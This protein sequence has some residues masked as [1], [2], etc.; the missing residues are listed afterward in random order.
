MVVNSWSSSDTDTVFTD[1]FASPNGEFIAYIIDK[2][3]YLSIDNGK[4]YTQ[5][6]ANL[7]SL[8]NSNGSTLDPT[9][10]IVRSS[11][12]GGSQS[13][14]TVPSTGTEM[15][16]SFIYSVVSGNGTVYARGS[17]L[18]TYTKGDSLETI[19]GKT[20]GVDDIDLDTNQ[21]GNTTIWIGASPAANGLA[22][23]H[24][25][26]IGLY[27]SSP[28]YDESTATGTQLLENTY[29]LNFVKLVGIIV[30]GLMYVTNSGSTMYFYNDM[31]AHP[32]EITSTYNIGGFGWEQSQITDIG[33]ENIHGKV[34]ATFADGRLGSIVHSN[35]SGSWKEWPAG[36]P[37]YESGSNFST[38]TNR[39]D[40]CSVSVDG[41]TVVCWEKGSGGTKF[42]LDVG[43]SVFYDMSPC[44]TI[45]NVDKLVV[46]SV[47]GSDIAGYYDTLLL[48]SSN[49]GLSCFVGGTMIMTIN[50]YARVE[51]LVVGNSVLTLDGYRV[52]K[53]IH[54]CKLNREDNCNIFTMKNLSVIGGH[55]IIV[56]D[57]DKVKNCNWDALN[58]ETMHIKG[59]KK[60]MAKD[61]KGFVRNTLDKDFMYYHFCLESESDTEQFVVLSNDIPSESMSIK[62][63]DR[64]VR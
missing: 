7:T 5:I 39:L 32:T 59:H 27:K 41:N 62:C 4:T 26:T 38:V 52:I 64:W 33:Y 63:F 45:D 15:E 16:M 60:I 1:V 34:Y 3:M 30:N 28:N 35:L 31:W 56:D 61:H 49:Y 42:R 9:A 17:E 22:Y 37:V 48:I 10:I 23:V 43:T 6:L 54:G 8:D 29:D 11:I 50:G 57:I 44:V 21:V 14:Y 58:Y 12:K 24:F 53:G 2:K 36:D 47:D 40:G 20:T 25:N 51:N 13:G 46:S 18:F 55:G 19:A